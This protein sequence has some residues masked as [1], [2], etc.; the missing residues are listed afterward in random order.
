VT[1]DSFGAFDIVVFTAL[2][3]AVAFV[4]A[5]VLSPSLRVR[6]ERPKYRFQELLKMTGSKNE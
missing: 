1:G 6:I 4:V 5:W 3:C 2:I